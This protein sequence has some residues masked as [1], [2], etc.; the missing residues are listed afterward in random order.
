MVSFFDMPTPKDP[1]RPIEF[2]TSVVGGFIGILLAI[3]LIATVFGS[4]SMLGFGEHAV[5]VTA[6][7]GTLDVNASVRRPPSRLMRDAPVPP[8][9]VTLSVDRISGCTVQPTVAQ[10]LWSSTTQWPTFLYAVGLWALLWRLVRGARREGI[11]TGTVSRRT[12]FLGWYVVVGSL[13]AALVESVATSVLRNELLGTH[14]FTF[15][16]GGFAVA[17]FAGVGLV[18]M[19]RI[20]DQ[21]AAMQREIDATV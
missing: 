20:L 5:C 9:G 2:L 15:W 18:T 19:G 8:R 14:S 11:H 10:R 13:A 6:P 12:R 16:W 21:S 1:L 17:V 3:G 7:G 4:G